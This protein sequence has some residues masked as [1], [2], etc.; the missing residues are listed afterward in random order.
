MP[1]PMAAGVLGI[2]RTIAAPAGSASA[3]ESKVRPAMIEMTTE[4]G[5]TRPPI[6]ASAC[7]AVCG[8]T[9]MTTASAPTADAPGLSRSPRAA[10]AAIC[11][12]G[13]GSMTVTP[14]GSTPSP[15]QPSS[16]APPIFPAPTR[17]M[18]TDG[19]GEVDVDMEDLIGLRRHRRACPGDLD[20][21]GTASPDLEMQS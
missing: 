15:I 9:A 7:G 6:S 18:L 3:R 4:P 16:N 14:A 17:T 10:S 12:D 13:C 1:R 2:A 5:A 21:E 20:Y 11:G 19:L 8:L